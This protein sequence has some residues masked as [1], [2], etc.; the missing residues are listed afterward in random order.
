MKATKPASYRVYL[1]NVQTVLARYG[2]G[3]GK[4]LEEAQRNA[5][6]RVRDLGF[7]PMLSDCGHEVRFA[8]GIN[9]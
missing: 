7:S 3:E 2:Y 1:V 6:Q 4:T 9:S 5:M 8:G